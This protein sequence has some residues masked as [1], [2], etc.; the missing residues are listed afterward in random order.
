METHQ[1]DYARLSENE[2]AAAEQATSLEEC[3]AHFHRAV[4][5]A[6]LACQAHQRFPGFNVADIRPG[7]RR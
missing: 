7:V 4:R 5:F 1:L 3:Q 6:S 2:M